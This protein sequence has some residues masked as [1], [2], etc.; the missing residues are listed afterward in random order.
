MINVSGA[1]KQ[2]LFN[3]NRKYVEQVT[4]TLADNTV[5]NLT[6]ENLWNGGFEIDDAV[7]SD[8]A[9]TALGSAII[10]TSTIVINNMYDDFSDYDFTN[11]KVVMSVGL[12]LND[13]DTPRT[14]MCRKGTY[15]VDEATYNG[16]LITIKTMDY[17]AKFDEPY[18]KSTL[19]YPATADEI[20]RNACTL[21]GVTLATLDFPNKTFVIDEKPNEESVTF[22]EVIS[23]VATICGC[24]ARC[25]TNGQLELKWYDQDYYEEVVSQGTDGGQF[26]EDTPYSTGDSADGGSFN[27]WDTGDAVDGGSFTDLNGAHVISSIYSPNIAVDDVV[28]TGVVASFETEVDGKKTTESYMSGDT[29]YLITI[30]KNPMITGTNV[31][32]IV[33]RLGTQLIGLK[34]RK[35][36]ISHSSDPTIEAG[37]LAVIVDRKG[38][39]YPIL[40]TRTHFKVGGA[41]TTVCG[42]ETPARKSASRFSEATKNAVQLRKEMEEQKTAYDRALEELAEE[43]A[44]AEGMYETQVQTQGGG[45]ITYMHNKPLLAESDVQIMIS[46]VGVTVTANGTAQNPTWYGLTVNGTLI[47][48][49]MNTIGINF[50]WGVG[51]ALTIE[52]TNGD[53]TFYANAETGVVRI[54]ATSFSLTDGTSINSM[55]NR[56]SSKY[57]TCSTAAATAAKAVTL[58]NFELFTGATISVKFTYAN[59]SDNPTLNVNNTGAKTIRAFNANLTSTSAYNW[60]ANSIVEFVYDGT[61]WQLSANYNQQEIFN[62]LTNNLSNQGIYLQNGN[63]YVNA[64]MIKTGTLSADYIYGGTLTLGGSD[65]VN[66]QLVIKNAAGTEIGS[67]SKDGLIATDYFSFRTKYNNRTFALEMGQVPILLDDG[68]T[69]TAAG[70]KLRCLTSYSTK[71]LSLSADEAL[72]SGSVGTY[73]L[74]AADELRVI[75]SASTYSPYNFLR[76]RMNKGLF[77]LSFIGLST[78]GFSY[79]PAITI[80]GNIT[81]GTT[82]RP[83]GSLGGYWTY[84]GTQI[85]VTS[86]SAKRYKTNIT[87]KISPDLDAHKLYELKMKEF[88]YKDD[89]EHLQYA[90][91]KGQTIGGF[92]AE[93]VAEIYPS[94]VIHDSEG[95]IESWDERRILPAMLKLIQEQH[96]EIERLKQAI[97]H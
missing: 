79:T 97:Q 78:G 1:F 76:I 72:A 86:S 70:M 45:M 75:T 10:N 32:T 38:I 71:F 34:F 69:A 12:E 37:D 57:G 11:A 48:S 64:S 13:T 18:S 46:D 9:F 20:V 8:N 22:R 93:D 36:T 50:D 59:T 89:F 42:A 94:A 3:D 25:N 90:D 62:R 91:L 82:I 47:A 26:D 96:E 16:S 24:Y 6:N 85:A 63:L 33:D 15:I 27:P 74:Y 14:E 61:Y 66:G 4:I 2:A 80:T 68:T 5:L 7:S 39:A 44:N 41:Q 43:I 88:K 40:V 51:G 23:Y 21:C 17:M 95:N 28:I 83:T 67:W 29:G 49:I 73:N 55:A 31:Q 54:R 65:N 35:A 84:N 53:E 56:I 19:A 60:Q 52:D 77:D 58:G 87:E 30:A 92:I 81:Q